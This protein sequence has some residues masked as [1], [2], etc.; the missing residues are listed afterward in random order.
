MNLESYFKR[1]QVSVYTDRS[2]AT[3]MLQLA[4]TSDEANQLENFLRECAEPLPP[5]AAG[6]NHLCFT[7]SV[8][9]ANWPDEKKLVVQFD[10]FFSTIGIGLVNGITNMCVEEV[11]DA[12]VF[13]VNTQTAVSKLPHSHKQHNMNHLRMAIVPSVHDL[14]DLLVELGKEKLK[15]EGKSYKYFNPHQFEL[16]VDGASLVVAFYGDQICFGPKVDN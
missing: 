9:D 14:A 15:S 4:R 1:P 2:V 10:G 3:P 16:S 11:W 6:G 12:G 7:I 5:D 13:C 8:P